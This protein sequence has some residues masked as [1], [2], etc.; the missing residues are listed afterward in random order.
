MAMINRKTIYIILLSIVLTAFVAFSLSLRNVL[1]LWIDL[2]AGFIASHK[3]LGA[4]GFVAL[5]GLSVLF[6][7]FTS[8]PL[9]PPAVTVWG[10]IPTLLLLLVGW[11]L[12]NITAYLIGHHFG[13]PLVSKI[14]KKTQLD[15]WIEYTRDQIPFVFALLF[16]I[17]TPS[18]TGYVFG[19]LKY[20]FKK[21]LIATA[22]AEIPFAILAVYA[23]FSFLAGDWGNVIG[24][25]IGWLVVMAVAVLFFRRGL[26]KR[27]VSEDGV[28]IGK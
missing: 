9:I 14:V 22:L 7:P 25:L 17:A 11:L 15:K 23:S 20:S 16:R 27:P 21:Y 13:Y 24:Y 4:A 18:E 12:G 19:L 5:A 10:N 28:R 8:T 2:V 6:G 1:F 3:I 26:K